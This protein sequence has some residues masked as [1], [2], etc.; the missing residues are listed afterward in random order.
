MKITIDISPYEAAVLMRCFSQAI[1]R[2]YEILTKYN[3]ADEMPAGF[4]TSI[5]NG[6]KDMYDLSFKFGEL[7]KQSE[8]I[9]SKA[10]DDFVTMDGQWDRRFKEVSEMMEAKNKK[11]EAKRGWSNGY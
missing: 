6:M 7:V 1:L 5:R 9:N 10:V 3:K 11:E 4:I 8:S 2:Y